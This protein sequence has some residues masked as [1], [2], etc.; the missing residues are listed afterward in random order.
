MWATTVVSPPSR[1]CHTILALKRPHEGLRR[2]VTCDFRSS[3]NAQILDQH[4]TARLGKPQAR[5]QAS[6]RPA[7]QRL[8]LLDETRPRHPG[9]FRQLTQVPA[10]FGCIQIEG[11]SFDELSFCL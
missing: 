8:E 6:W 11:Q 4:A 3:L 1:W 10:L 5:Y 9:S 7:S 2:T